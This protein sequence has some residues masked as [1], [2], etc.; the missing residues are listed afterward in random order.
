MDIK[1]LIKKRLIDENGN[2]TFYGLMVLFWHYQNA[3]KLPVFE[4]E[5]EAIG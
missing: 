1:T 2:Y 3:D 4:A 5:Y